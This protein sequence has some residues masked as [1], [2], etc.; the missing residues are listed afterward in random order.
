MSARPTP[1]LPRKSAQ[2]ARTREAILAAAAKLLRERGIAGTNVADVMRAAGLTVGGF[3]A[4]FDSK[5]AL[6]EASLHRCLGEWRGK[7]LGRP[8]DEPWPELLEGMLERYLSAHHRDEPAGGCPLPAV[9]AEIAIDGTGRQALAAELAAFTEWLQ[10]G[11][12]GEH[13]RAPRNAVLGSLALMLGGL[14]FS[15]ALRGTPMSDE[16]LRAVSDRFPP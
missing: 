8:H 4:H 11:C 6:I 3:Y 10:K 1:S 12:Q 2:K 16:F 13:E 5:E 15:R 14:L 9:T 7:L